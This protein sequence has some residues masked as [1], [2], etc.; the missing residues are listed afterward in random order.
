MET[1]EEVRDLFDGWKKDDQVFEHHGKVGPWA[2]FFPAKKD[3]V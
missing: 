1:T 3:D 2:G